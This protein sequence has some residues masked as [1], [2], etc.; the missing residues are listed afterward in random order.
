MDAT[1]GLDGSPITPWMNLEGREVAKE[2]Q[3]AKKKGDKGR[4]KILQKINRIGAMADKG[5]KRK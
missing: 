2:I 1:D 4:V 5:L 3:K